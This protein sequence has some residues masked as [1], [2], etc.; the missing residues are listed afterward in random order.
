MLAQ[1]H[2]INLPSS[3]STSRT[4]STAVYLPRTCPLSSCSSKFEG[5]IT[6]RVRTRKER[7]GREVGEEGRAGEEGVVERTMVQQ[8]KERLVVGNGRLYCFRNV[9]GG[10]LSAV[11][12]ERYGDNSPL[13]PTGSTRASKGRYSTSCSICRSPSVSQ[14]AS[15]PKLNSFALR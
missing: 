15:N 4:S 7:R 13:S 12:L 14:Y 8:R 5:S 3:L 1:R 11:V 2:S 6:G 9:P 10:F